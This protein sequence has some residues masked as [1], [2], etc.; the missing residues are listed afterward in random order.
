MFLQIGQFESNS[1]ANFVIR[2][3]TALHVGVQRSRADPQPFCGILFIVETP[4][5]WN[6]GLVNRQICCHGCAGRTGSEGE[7]AFALIAG[8]LY[9]GHQ[10]LVAYRKFSLY[11][12]ETP[13]G[14][15]AQFLI[16][17]SCCRSLDCD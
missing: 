15:Q 14:L 10:E 7:N 5:I 13:G 9:D 4:G 11:P 16:S 6:S 3:Q 8:I 17:H 12:G 2:D 1:S